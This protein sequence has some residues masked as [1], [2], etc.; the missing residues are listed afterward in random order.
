MAITVS[1]PKEFTS[2]P[3]AYPASAKGYLFDVIIKNGS[4]EQLDPF[5]INLQ[6]TSG[7]QQAEPIIDVEKG[8]NTPS[9][10]ILPGRTLKYKAAFEKPGEKFTMQVSYGF[11]NADGFYE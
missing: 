4:K 11:G 6:A 7:D 5:M 10:A 3:N 8:I 2:G 1:K 9:A